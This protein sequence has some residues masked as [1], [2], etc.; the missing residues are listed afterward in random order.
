MLDWREDGNGRKYA[1]HRF[2]TNNCDE[3]EFKKRE[4]HEP[5][6]K[7]WGEEKNGFD[8]WS[9]GYGSQKKRTGFLASSE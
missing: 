2:L 5:P 3:G 8:S 7:K 1:E 4:I 6:L 9:G